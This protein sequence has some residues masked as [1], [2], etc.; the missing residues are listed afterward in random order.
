MNEPTQAI[1]VSIDHLASQ[2]DGVALF[3][4]KSIFVPY[5][6]VGDTVSLKLLHNGDVILLDVIKAGTNR[7]DPVCRHFMVCGGCSSQHLSPDTYIQFKQN[8]LKE[9]ISRAG[10][11]SAIVEELVQIPPQSRRRAEFKVKVEKKQVTLGFYRNKTHDVIELTHCPVTSPQ[12]TALLPTLKLTLEQLK[13]AGHVEAVQVSQYD[14]GIEVIFHCKEA[15]LQR[16]KAIL[17]NCVD[18]IKSVKRVVVQVKKLSTHEIL[19]QL[20]P[21]EMHFGQSIVHV[22]VGAFIQATAKAQNTLIDTLIS[23]VEP[24][25]H[26]AD[27]YAGCGTYSFPLA[28][29]ASSVSAYEGNIEMV[30]AANNAIKRHKLQ[31]N[32]YFSVQDLVAKP[33][34]AHMLSGK[35]LVIINPPRAGA[36]KQ[37][38]EVIKAKVQY[39][40][41][42][43]CNPSTLSRDLSYFK[44]AGYRLIRA[45]PVDQF[46]WT[47]HLESL[48]LLAR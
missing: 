12:I 45:I 44:Q 8:I 9:A 47:T 21:L 23:I 42:I 6:A 32:L 24:D 40:A 1:T 37:C 34:I 4:G 36:S 39:V 41:M 48:V 31:N 30:I 15:L 28:E 22:P 16:D 18:A 13:K 10:F 43:S 5:T 35:D 25:M 27:L 20:E 3:E 33:V 17:A 38:Q 7:V 26:I 2:G 19:R 11:D 14:N 46:L 29:K